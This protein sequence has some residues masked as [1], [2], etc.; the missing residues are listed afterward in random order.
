MSSEHET[1]NRDYWNG[2]ARDWVAA[3]ERLW[4]SD[5]EWG[6]WGLPEADLRLLPDDMSQM[7]AI[8]LGCGTGYVSGWMVRRGAAATAID[9]SVAQLATARRLS[10]Q[11][12]AE[13]DFVI[14]SAEAVPRADG[15]F[16]FAISEYGAAI[17][18]DPE[19]WLREAWRLLRS[20][21]ELVFL[22]NHPLSMVCTPANGA[23][24]GFSLE[25]SYRTLGRLDWSEVKTDPG[26]VEFNRSISGWMRLF[27][28]IGFR[29]EEFQELYAPD[30][31]TDERFGVPAN[32]AKDFPSEQVWRLRKA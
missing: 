9:I 12:G 14:G 31:L 29:V 19:R 32:W 26:G 21:G 11:H 17:W 2:M 28:E 30:A 6:I 24:A 4:G 23:A 15:S 3:G 13:I 10:A 18:C 1:I 22:G 5:P 16:D 20:G 27:R 8:E 7:A 25:M